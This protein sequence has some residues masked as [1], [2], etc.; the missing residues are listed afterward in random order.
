MRLTGHKKTLEGQ[1]TMKNLVRISLCFTAA[2]G[3]A[4]ADDV[5]DWNRITLD[6]L[7][8]PPAVGAPL[9]Q[10]PAAMVQA[11]V[12]DAVN[13]IARR[14]TP[15]HVLPGAAPGASKRAAAVQAAYAILIRLFPGQT[16]VLAQKRALS[17][18]AIAA[19]REEAEDQSIERGIEWGQ[20]VADAIWAWRSTDGSST[21]LPPFTG[22]LAPGEWR[23]TPPSFAPGLAPQLAQE[24]PWAIP[25]PSRFR[26]GG[27]PALTSDRYTADYNEVMSLGAANSAT[28]SAD[29]TLYA[30]FWQSASPV[31]FWDPVATS[32]STAR[33]F[34][35]L[36][37][38][39]LLAYLNL[40]LA[41]AVTGCWDA[42]YTYVSWR[43]V[44]AIQLGDMDGNPDTVADPAWAPLITTPPFPEY[45]SA[46]SC[47]S[48]A[49][50]RVLSAYFGDNTQFSV[51]SDGMPGVSRS[52][53][54]FT[55]A[56]DEVKNARIV[57]G[58]HFRSACEDGQGLG[59]AVADYIL[60]HSLVRIPDDGNE[61]SDR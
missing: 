5:T 23:P 25:S 24:T 60:R 39:R 59:V 21:V 57:G 35:L 7:L 18:A 11:A 30:H 55:A 13:G 17:L 44:T 9:A 32:L 6:R 36:E 43:P 61:Q 26:P 58:I 38:A 48:G 27:P 28:R 15:V 20:T 51:T 10:R 16:A 34:S 42:K 40:A 53:S 22:G 52:F 33:D 4:T 50:G 12:F 49:A 37:N 1:K 31:D 2:V 3:F 56:L 54:S 47:V 19:D 29:Q 8:G 45:P 14:Y 41:D 46:H